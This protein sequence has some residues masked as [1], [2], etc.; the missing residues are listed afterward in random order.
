MKQKITIALVDDD[1]AVSDALRQYLQK[2]GFA[3]EAFSKAGDLVKAL[4]G[5]TPPPDCIVSDIRMP[6]MSGMDLQRWLV[7]NRHAV[8]LILMTGYADIEVAVAAMKA[9]AVD[10]IEKPIDE[11]RLLASIRQAVTESQR[12]QVHDGARARQLS[13]LDA[14]SD[15][16]REVFWLISQGRT[17]RE[18]GAELGI[19]PRTVDIHRAS[20]MEKAACTTLAELI[21]LAVSIETPPENGSR[22]QR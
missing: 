15:R 2:R 12:R 19:S 4:L 14:L 21:R 16:E 10:F 5:N 18:I 7:S 11:R 9:G 13:R 1:D 8:P 22:S 3:V 17:S 20:V 6:G